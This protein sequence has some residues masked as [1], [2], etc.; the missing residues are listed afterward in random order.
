MRKLLIALVLLIGA[1]FIIVHF[2]EVQAILETFQ[3]GDWRF[4]LF[5][6]VVEAAWMLNLAA[7]F[8]AVFRALGI[9]APIQRLFMMATAANFVNVVAPSG[10]MGGLAVLITEARRDNYSAARVAV[11]GVLLVLFDYLA[12]FCVLT[13]GLIALVRRNNLNVSEL[14]ASGIMVGIALF[15]ALMLFLGM[16]SEETLGRT[17]AWLARRVNRVVRPFIHREY[18]SEARAFAFAQE[19]AEGLNLISNDPQNLILPAA[20]ALSNKA[21]MISVLF[22]MFLAF[23]VPLSVGTLIAGFTI[24]YLFTIVSPTPAGI[25]IVETALALGLRSLYVP[26]GAAAVITLAYRGYTFW[27]PFI[28][29]MMTVRLIDKDK[30]TQEADLME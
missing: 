2:A 28:V 9:E 12:F 6:M 16:R 24:G 29:G 8:R 14:I 25:G 18:L 19:A 23:K 15:L 10:G 30:E 1:F 21:F 26:L 11:A 27:L 17:L 20:L 22:L 13:L 5:A 4:L 3:R 7:S